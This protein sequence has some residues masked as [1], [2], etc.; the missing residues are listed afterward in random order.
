MGVV[1]ELL[2][3]RQRS[4]QKGVG[5][6]AWVRP[7]QLPRA[8]TDFAQLYL[9]ATRDRRRFVS[10]QASVAL[11][12]N[13]AQRTPSASRVC[14]AAESDSLGR[15]QAEVRWGVHAAEIEGI[16]SVARGLRDQLSPCGL[17]AAE[18]AHWNESLVHG[19]GG[20]AGL[21]E[22]RHAMGGACFG[23]DP[24]TSVVDGQLKVHGVDNLHVASAAVLPD[25]RAQLPTM[26]LM[27]L[28]L[29]LADRLRA[30]LTRDGAG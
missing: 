25:G 14:L 24:R 3:S 8:L 20:I 27:A 18:G 15:Q 12:L 6:A 10:R 13:V 7:G 26:T 30:E 28:S 2:R 1:R 21:D 23:T 17:G 5:S 22:A 4:W 19:E 9:A 16:R 11:R 29:R